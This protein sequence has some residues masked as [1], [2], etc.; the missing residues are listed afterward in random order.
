LCRQI[1]YTM[2][3]LLLPTLLLFSA[4]GQA[5]AINVSNTSHTVPQLVNNVLINSPC[6][7][8]TNVTWSTGTNFSSSNGLG[9]FVNTNPNFPMQSGVILSTG[10]AV[11]AQGPNTSMLDDGS[12]SWPGDA[13][14]EATLLQAGITMTSTNATVLEF[15]FTPISSHFNF[16]FVFASEEYGNFQCQFSDAF[17]FLLTNMNTGVTTNL[18]VVP[19]TNTPISVVT[20]RDFLYNSSCPSANAQ[21]FGTFNGG[22]AAA[23][24]A[25]NFNGQ[26]KLLNASAVL[27][28]NTPYHIKLVI[29]DRSD[30]QSDSAIFINSDSFNIGQDVL[31]LDLTT[32]TNTAVC[33]GETQVLSTDLDPADY[34]FVWTKNGTTISG[35][36][37]PS[38]N[39]TQPGTY[40][41]TYT[42]IVDLC[43]PV[44][45]NIIIQFNPQITTPN[46]KDL[47]KCNVG[48]ATYNFDLSINT[49]II[50]TGLDPLTQVTYHTSQ[51]NATNNISP[52]P[53]NYN[54]APGQ[55]IYA[56]IQ[57]PGT[58]CAIVKS[59][60]LLLSPPPVA[61]TLPD[62]TLCARSLTQQSA[63]VHLWTLTAPALNG[64]SAT[65]NAV[66]YYS[67]QA[68]ANNNVNPITTPTY[69]VTNGSK[70]YIRIQ[71]A[72]DPSCYS[73]SNFMVTILSLP[74]VD[75]FEDIVVCEDYI[76]PPLTNGNYF[77]GLNGTGTHL[78]A[79]DTISATQTI[80]IFNQPGGPPNCSAG[81]K[82]KVT[83]IDPEQLDPGATTACG[84]YALPP[85]TL[86]K[87]FSAPNGGGLEIPAGTVLTSSQMVYIYF[88]AP[89]PP[90][91]VI[92]IDVN[93]TIIPSVQLGSFANIFD[94]NSYMLP[95]LTAGKYYP[96]P[97]GQ[98]TEI[99]GGTVITATQTIYVYAAGGT[100][101]HPC[102][103]SKQFVV[104]IGM[105]MPS[106]VS[107]CNPY[108]LPVLASGKYFTGPNGTGTEIP[109]GTV[110]S[111]SQTIYIYIAG[112]TQSCISD[113]HFDVNISQPTVDTLQNVSM[114]ETYT[115]PVL[116][117][118]T[119]Y[120]GPGKSGSQLFAGDV[121]LSTQTIYIYAE[122][123]GGCSNETSFT[124]T[125][126]PLPE[127]D[128]RSDIDIC[129]SYTLTALE[130]GNYY[131]GPNGTGTLLTAGTVITTTQK[132]Y[133]YATGGTNGCTAQNSFDINIFS[134]E[135]DS[136]AAVT[137]CDSYVLP[138]LTIGN[139][140]ANSGGPT[141]NT[142]MLH[143][144]DVIT[145]STTL[146]IYT[147]SGERINCTDENVFQITINHTPVVAPIPT[148]NACNSFTLPALAV[149]NYF[150]GAAGTGTMLHQGDV[151]TANQTVY[152]YA[153]TGTTP[154]CTDEKSFSV[155]IF[156]VD[157]LADVTICESYVLPAL[158]VGKYYT[159]PAGTGTVLNAGSSVTVSKTIYVYALSP[160]TPACSSETSFVVTIIDT[161]VAYPVTT[162]MRTVCDE[163]GTNDG[164]TSFDLTS[165]NA[166]ILGT[167][168]GAEFTIAYYETQANANTATN[169]VTSTTLTS[170]FVRVSNTL[171][172]LCFD[173][174]PI[175][176]SVNKLPEP[177]PIDGIMCFNTQTNTLI[178]PYVISSGLSA[179]GHTFQWK[180]EAGTIVGTSSTYTA[181]TPGIY[182]ITVTKT[183]TG[184]VSEPVAV[185]VSPS[186]PAVVSYSITDDFADSQ[187]ITVITVGTGDYEYQLDFGSFQDSPVFNNVSSGIHLVT[188]RDKN[189]CGVSTTNALVVNYPHYFTPNGDGIHDTWN[190]VDLNQ[191]LDSK[192]HIFDRYGKLLTQITPNGQGWDGTY[193]GSTMPST[194][195][196]FVVEY[197]EDGVK[198]EFRAHFAMK[199]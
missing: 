199:R 82:F 59:F 71:N 178:S 108:T 148:Q 113:V 61:A 15:D 109:G 19:S 134:I 197:E 86:G 91:C 42:N 90:F 175:T 99:P 145:A 187:T 102:I 2:N 128:S 103:D 32:A 110:I 84:S 157:D 78:Y 65:I 153:Q 29:A 190:I 38:L 5:Q 121:I 192:I 74:T 37:G 171:A 122:I 69:L 129:N 44:T 76:L 124:V 63:Y 173:V 27:T 193:N 188:V 184:C 10:S 47:Y 7:E 13:N 116:A 158:T 68:N 118:G 101:A 172:P 26:T 24:S 185:T 195:Y 112:N 97:N 62:L 176:I 136:P 132:I 138:A 104:T 106:N 170:V 182:T 53:E 73:T 162:A 43:Q 3:K 100:I 137:T 85:L 165:L 154:N 95:I 46:P 125:I 140:Y 166:T 181:I 57:A 92:D 56:R 135:A 196:W 39:V 72:T 23:S 79:G 142:T 107:Q 98:G 66:T 191:Q 115:L 130:A 180:N 159:G 31:G 35:A 123:S 127:I 77:S 55:T 17:A 163:D 54:S 194:D 120:S 160:F 168:T 174:K 114:C 11:N 169:A 139:Y 30:S 186:E 89:T 88:V 150:T 12:P 111:Q 28:P 156:K 9:Y 80:Y 94:C 151:L 131:T 143:A 119:Y 177:T 45:D 51:A 18:A 117:N 161:P 14:L 144:G 40:G 105:P 64:Q 48:A 36:N 21:Y 164:I 34:T 8:A 126:N 16:D 83:V 20:I 50:K 152:V 183:A 75:T 81:S 141:N 4:L 49:V 198:K 149:G 179:A 155:N 70:V 22:S 96:L 1:Y 25:T 41:V 189:G 93:V 133:I 6:V 58:N 147:E 52:L 87:Y 60:Q 146:Y 67:T 167:Q 33:Y